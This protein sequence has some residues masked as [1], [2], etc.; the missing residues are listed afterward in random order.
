MEHS[1]YWGCQHHHFE[2]RLA[3]YIESSLESMFDQPE[4]CHCILTLLT[5]RATTILRELSTRSGYT[6]LGERLPC[7]L[8]AETQGKQVLPKQSQRFNVWF[9]RIHIIS[10]QNYQDWEHEET[11]YFETDLREPMFLSID[12]KLF[13]SFFQGGVNPV[14]FEPLGL[15]RM[16]MLDVGVWTEPQLYGHQV[17][18]Q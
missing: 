3:S 11:L 14:D 17:R 7:I 2:V 18:V 10:S 5:W 15:F 1:S 6:W 12:D 4:T 9:Y 8:L 13:F 16:E